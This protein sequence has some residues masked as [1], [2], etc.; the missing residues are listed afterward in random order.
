MAD[1]ASQFKTGENVQD[2]GRYA[3]AAG[4]KRDFNKGDAFPNCP[5]SGKATTWERD[6][7][8]L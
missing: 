8:V 3:C 7:T 4:E 1:R 5:V 2:A 6:V